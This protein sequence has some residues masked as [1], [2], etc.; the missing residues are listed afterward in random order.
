MEPR[1]SLHGNNHLA[2]G[3]SVEDVLRSFSADPEYGL[4]SKEALSRE[5]TWGRNQ[6]EARRRRHGLSILMAQ[7]KSVVVILLLVAGVLAFLFADFAEGLAILAVILI[8]AMIGFITEWRAVRSMEALKE[9]GRVDCILLRDGK[10]GNAAAECLVPGDIVLFEAGALVPADVRLISASKLTVD[11]S[12]LTGESLPVHKSNE[13]LDSETAMLDRHNMAFKG[14]SITRGSG[15]GV[16]VGTGRNTEFGRIFQQV[17]EAKP[18]QTPLEK[19]L[20]ALG[21]R[22]AWAIIGIAVLVAVAGIAA[23]RELF[24]AIE[25]AIA[26]SVAAIPEGLAIV[27]TIALARGMWRMAKRNALIT[28]LSAVETLGATSVIL[29]D[30]TGTLTEN[31]M[32]VSTVLLARCDV[33]VD[34]AEKPAAATFCVNGNGLD[35]DIAISIDALLQ[36][37]A[38]CSNAALHESD[39]SRAAGVGDPTEVAL[40][41]LASARGLWR[42]A[43][44]D[45][46]P[47]LREDPFDP[48]TKRM[49]TLH[50]R[51]DSIL[52]SVK[53]APE[54]ILPICVA[55]RSGGDDLPLAEPERQHWLNRAERLGDRGLRTIAIATKLTD[56]EAA[57][58]YAE[59]VLLGIIGLEDPA[60]QGVDRAIKRCHE[61]GISVVMVTGDHAATAR[62]IAMAT[63]I[64]PTAAEEATCVGGEQVDPLFAGDDDDALLAA[65]VFSRVTPE[66]KLKLIDL[67]QRN[68]QVVAMT[69]DGVNDAPALKKA[70]IG[71]AM[72][73][74]GT[75]VAKEAAVMVLQDDEFDSI[76]AAVAHGRAIFANIRKFVV[77]L[78]SCNTSEVLV[79]SLATIAGAPLP[80]LPLQILFLNLVTDV[81]PALALGVGRG[82]RSLMRNTPRPAKE[83]ILRR[84]DWISIGLHGTVMSAAVLAAMAISHYYFHFDQR[85]AVTV[86]FCT[87]A[88]AQMWHVFNM[89]DEIKR[90]IVN[91]I[92][93]NGWVWA[94]LGLC[95][96][97]VL[98]AVY[99]PVLSDVLRLSNPGVRGWGL[100]LPA[101]IVP[102]LAAPLVGVIR[103]RLIRANP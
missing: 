80:L 77:Y 69:G 97:L 5:K 78:L 6:L 76:V 84:A 31:R 53:G 88:F 72:G 27:A 9:F 62:N 29:T 30:K 91:E 50:R 67:Y 23:G 90:V 61:A 58:P 100:I 44:L 52:F 24:L 15:K 39:D 59:L 55:A 83:R 32:A 98:A 47:E 35:P 49:A 94:A 13:K 54:A 60:R 37:G 102:L 101:S 8:N 28:R 57:D 36:A 82:S 26:L 45:E 11:E 81:F 65:R 10:I 86:A 74:R 99:W 21:G 41:V 33:A 89:R 70:D 12:T 42:Q 14:T 92:T 93:G 95:L 66:Q 43:L 103:E 56:D 85:K 20:N 48:D 18:Q 79:V 73:L 64:L 34:G 68:G 46:T 75:A 40:L 4:D 17:A 1:G 96:I 38:L 63:G 22:L 51:D 19:R 25:V 2:W 16:V 3:R 7:F 87:L 71:I